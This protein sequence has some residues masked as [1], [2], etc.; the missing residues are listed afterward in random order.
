MRS[1]IKLIEN[2]TSDGDGVGPYYYMCYM[3][4]KTRNYI[5]L[6]VV[7]QTNRFAEQSCFM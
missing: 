1:S 6:S 7:K 3:K 2:Y 4:V 5:I